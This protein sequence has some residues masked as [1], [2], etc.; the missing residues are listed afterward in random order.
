MPAHITILW[1]FA[2]PPISGDDRERLREIASRTPNFE[3]AFPG[4]QRFP[5][6]LWL[7]P[8]PVQPFIDL[9]H[10]L[11][12]CWPSYVPY[13]GEH[14]EIIPHLT[15]AQ[16]KDA[17]LDKVENAIAAH[18]PVY[19]RARELTLLTEADGRWSVFE[20]YEMGG[21]TR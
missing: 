21:G 5:R 16:G 17:T 10:R 15:V 1:P 20:T 7:A 6:V 14:A 4:M 12:R 2:I 19:G 11:V 3:F 8:Q 13:G 18:L 9:T